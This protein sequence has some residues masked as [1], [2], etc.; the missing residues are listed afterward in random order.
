MTSITARAQSLA[1]GALVELFTLDCTMIDVAGAPGGVYTF[2][3]SAGHV[4]AFGGVEY[5]PVDIEADGFE[6]TGAG[7]LPTPKLRITNVTRVLA[8]LAATA[9]DL[10]GA[11]VTRLRT[12]VE[13]L[14]GEPGADPEMCFPPDIYR[15]ERLSAFSK[16]VIEWELSAALD[17]QGRVLPGRQVLQGACTHRYRRWDAASGGFD[18]TSATCPWTGGGFT[19][20]GQAT[21]DPAADRCGKR[22]ADCRLRFGAGGVLP[23]RAFPA[24]AKT[25]V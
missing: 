19:A 16:T 2:T 13:F 15:V 20:Q 23:T 21:A 3:P 25:R 22:L 11:Q 6:V 4:L 17:Q 10:L 18:Y 8:A 14:D 24:V 9:G 1:P 5:A 12:F 7:S